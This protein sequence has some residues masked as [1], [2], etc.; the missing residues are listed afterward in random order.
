MLPSQTDLYLTEAFTSF[1]NN[2][3]VVFELLF[4]LPVLLHSLFICCVNSV[5]AGGQTG[6]HI[7]KLKATLDIPS[8]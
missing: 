1:T 6:E 5:P 4:L 2:S 3:L 7:L 8:G